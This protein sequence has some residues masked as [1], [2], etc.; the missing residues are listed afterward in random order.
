MMG[1]SIKVDSAYGQGSVFTVTVPKVIGSGDLIPESKETAIE[2]SAP[3]TKILVVDDNEINLNVADGFLKLFGIEAD[4]ALSGVQAVGM[5]K[6]KEY[7]IVFMD[8][9][10]PDMDGAEAAQEIRKL[11]GAYERMKI[12]AFSANAVSGAKEM[13]FSSGFDDFLS[14]PIEFDKLTELLLKWLPEEKI[15]SPSSTQ[16]IKSSEADENIILRDEFFEKLKKIDLINI[17][18]GMGNFSQVPDNYRETLHMFYVAIV[19]ECEKMTSFLTDGNLRGFAISI[20]GMKGSLQTLGI[21]EPA[22]T[23][24]EL[25]MAAKSG[26]LEYCR[27]NF[28]AFAERMTG[29]KEALADVF[30]EEKSGG[31]LPKESAEFLLQKLQ[32]A[33]A[34]ANDL[35]GDSGVEALTALLGF[36]FSGVVELQIK[37]A[38]NSIKNYDFDK[39]LDSLN[40]MV[41]LYQ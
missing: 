35:D 30:T 33:I 40:K 37:N 15:E 19:S 38:I 9:L 24:Y 23:A 5:V 29:L 11:G 3:S 34:A 17:K 6:Q 8:Y 16:A 21:T 13:F 18:K 32:I 27:L 28:P 2:F 4:R 25:E 22:A 10:M 31:V 20:H 7:D 12:I 36:D 41:E 14:K 26:D 39:A 1:G